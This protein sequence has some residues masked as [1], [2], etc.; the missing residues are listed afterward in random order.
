MI[1]R[2][3]ILLL[4]VGCEEYAPTN[5]TH[6]DT[7]ETFTDTLFVYDTLIVTNYDTTIFNNYDTLIITNYDTTI[8][9]DTLI[10][11]NND[12]LVVMDTVYIETED[13]IHPLIGEWELIEVSIINDGNSGPPNFDNYSETMTFNI[14]GT[15]I[16]QENETIY[17]GLWAT[18]EPNTLTI[19]MAFNS[20]INNEPI[21]YSFSDNYLILTYHWA[22]WECKYTKLTNPL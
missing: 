22:S 12:T 11:T 14:D 8:A 2:L 7:G 10:V 1:R 9:Y 4:I 20:P 15:C 5:H 18:S 17:T 19:T 3:I 16:R 21:T 13:D 6:T